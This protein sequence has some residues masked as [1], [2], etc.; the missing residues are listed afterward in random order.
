MVNSCNFCKTRKIGRQRTVKVVP[1]KC[2]EF[3]FFPGASMCIAG[4]TDV[5]SAGSMST[6]NRIDKVEWI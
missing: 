2:A 6:I 1:N 4:R 3:E 5:V